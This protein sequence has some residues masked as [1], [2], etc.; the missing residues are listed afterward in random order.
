[1]GNPEPKPL[2]FGSS[3][4]L[5]Q[6]TP[7]CETSVTD[8]FRKAEIEFNILI[9]F[10]ENINVRCLQVF[11]LLLHTYFK[12]EIVYAHCCLLAAVNA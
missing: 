3:Y 1:M 7:F 11:L 5:N 12:Y 8:V 10:K 6:L 4:L 9:W 2:P